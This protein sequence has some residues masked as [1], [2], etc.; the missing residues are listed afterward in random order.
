MQLR[1]HLLRM[2]VTHRLVY[3][4]RRITTTTMTHCFKRGFAI[5][6]H[7]RSVSMICYEAQ[8]GDIPLTFQ[9]LCCV[10]VTADPASQVRMVR[11]WNVVQTRPSLVGVCRPFSADSGN[12]RSFSAR[13]AQSTSC[14]HPTT[15]AHGC[16]GHKGRV[17]SK[18]DH[19]N[20]LFL[21][22]IYEV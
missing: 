4:R 1:G 10:V 22:L 11:F 6:R 5:R 16:L 12:C 17:P 13:G 20:V 14:M 7:V 21:H 18:E 2:M 19:V 3:Q 8:N 15:R 9:F